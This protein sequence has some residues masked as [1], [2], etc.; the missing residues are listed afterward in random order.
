MLFVSVLGVL[1]GIY[2]WRPLVIERLKKEEEERRMRV[3]VSDDAMLKRLRAGF[4][5]KKYTQV[6][7]GIGAV[8]LAWTYYKVSRK[9][10]MRGEAMLVYDLEMKR[11][12]ANPDEGFVKEC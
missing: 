7:C 10:R 4:P 11:N 5:W 8:W 3:A 9:E 12:N 1:G 2:I 6:V